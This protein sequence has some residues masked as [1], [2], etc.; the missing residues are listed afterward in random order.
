MPARRRA[1]AALQ[2]KFLSVDNLLNIVRQ[3]AAVGIIACAATVVIIGAGFDLSVGAVYFLAGVASAWL[4]VHV[5]VP[6]AFIGG[7]AVG[8]VLGGFNGLLSTTLG[9][10]SFLATL[11]TSTCVTRASIGKGR[12]AHVHNVKTK[13]W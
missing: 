5:N 4:A 11:A 3:N 1:S 9:V 10:S 13:R 8:L 6:I 2:Q 12:H 7:V